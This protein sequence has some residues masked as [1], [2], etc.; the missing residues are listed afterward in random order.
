MLRWRWAWNLNNKKNIKMKKASDRDWANNER[1]GACTSNMCSDI[2]IYMGILAHEPYSSV[3]IKDQRF[4]LR[5]YRHL[6]LCK[7]CQEGY[8][9]FKEVLASNPV[10]YIKDTFSSINFRL[11]GENEKYLERLLTKKRVI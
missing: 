7:I 3:S 4:L 5:T 10:S 6:S 8:I 2:I 1:N 9:Y 11:L